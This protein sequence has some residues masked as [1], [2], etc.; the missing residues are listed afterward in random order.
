M[1][2]KILFLLLVVL[3]LS[4]YSYAQNCGNNIIDNGEECEINNIGN[5]SCS[6]YGF[7]GGYL[8]CKGCIL[9][10]SDCIAPANPSGKF[11]SGNASDAGLSLKPLDIA[12]IVAVIVIIIGSVLYIRHNG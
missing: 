4:G 12:L 5:A 2:D 6:D 7:Q 9:D 8:T 11:V 10:T 3:V 1:K